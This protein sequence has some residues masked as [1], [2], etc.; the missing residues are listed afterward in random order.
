MW[1]LTTNNTPAQRKIVSK[2]HALDI[3]DE[4]WLLNEFQSIARYGILLVITLNCINTAFYLPKPTTSMNL[5]K[6]L[7]LLF[8][9]FVFQILQFQFLKKLH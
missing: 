7:N 2:S 8:P 9:K 6:K 1:D 3:N 5:F 4:T